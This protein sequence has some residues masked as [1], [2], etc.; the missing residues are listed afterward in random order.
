MQMCQVRKPSGVH[1]GHATQEAS[2]GCLLKAVAVF[3]AS[4][5]GCLPARAAFKYI[6]HAS[7]CG[8]TYSMMTIAQLSCADVAYSF[9]CRGSKLDFILNTHHHWDHV[10]GN[11]ELKAK[12]SAQIVGPKADEAR[13][14]GIDMALAEGQTW[15]LGDLEMHV[16]DTPGHTKGHVTLW[17]PEAEVMFPG[18]QPCSVNVSCS[19]LL[20]QLCQSIEEGDHSPSHLAPYCA[21]LPYNRTCSID[22]LHHCRMSIERPCF[23]MHAMGTCPA[24][25]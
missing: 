9:I 25:A 23:V 7:F 2:F 3:L 14:P 5:L 13:I 12:Y 16:F 15:K 24:S 22:M 6:S 21:Y 8:C 17:F 18:E 10:G 1:K 4:F 20:Q 19:P 11:E